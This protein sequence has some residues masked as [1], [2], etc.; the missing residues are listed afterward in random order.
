M[1]TVYCVESLDS[2]ANRWAARRTNYKTTKLN[3]HS[4]SE[5][6]AMPPE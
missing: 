3:E 4:K 2:F 1:T 5:D 6:N